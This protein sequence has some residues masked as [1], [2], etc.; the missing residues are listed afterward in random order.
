M[1]L[2]S[3]R[4][5]ARTVYGSLATRFWAKVEVVRDD[6]SCWLWTAHLVHGYGMIGNGPAGTGQSHAHRVSWEIHF[7]PIPS[8]LGVLHHCDNK[9]CV[10]PDHLF[11]GTQADNMVDMASKFRGNSG[12][13][14]WKHKLTESEVRFIRGI[15]GLTHQQIADQFGVNRVT[16]TDVLSGRSWRHVG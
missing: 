4:R 16:V 3:A 12:S 15:K 1:P 11:L 13:R 5:R 6:H 7:G 14:M 9:A 2:I 8:G 10:R